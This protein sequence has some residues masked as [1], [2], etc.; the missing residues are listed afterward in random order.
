MQTNLGPGVSPLGLDTF[1]LLNFEK[2]HKAKVRA[3]EK[4][5]NSN[6]KVL[7]KELYRQ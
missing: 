4:I 5:V 6:L 2:G 7:K 1:K 3:G